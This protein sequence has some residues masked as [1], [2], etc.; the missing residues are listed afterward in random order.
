MVYIQPQICP[1][2]KD[3]ETPL[4]FRNTNG[5]PNL[6]QMTKTNN[7]QQKKENL[8]NRGLC[9]PDWSQ[10]KIERKWKEG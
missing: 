7:S 10:S 3:A 6:S 2:K 8:P 5:S 1:R 4:G 9:C